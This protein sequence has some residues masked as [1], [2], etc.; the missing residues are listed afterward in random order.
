M[1]ILEG[2]SR[3][4]VFLPLGPPDA[5]IQDPH[6]H[7]VEIPEQH[8]ERNVIQQTYESKELRHVFY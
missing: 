4:Y 1:T 8:L 6:F 5:E 3:C 7:D 2:I